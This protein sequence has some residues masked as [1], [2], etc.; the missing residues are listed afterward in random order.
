MKKKILKILIIALVLGGFIGLGYLLMNALG[1][2]NIDGLRNIV[3]NSFAGTIIFAVILI[4]QVIILPAGTLFFS[5]AAVVL[6]ES[7]LKAWLV[8]WFAL[9]IGSWIMF[10]IAR[11]LGM[12][13][14]KWVVGQERAEKYANFLGR[15]KYVLPL[16]LLVPIF[17]D[18]IVCAAAGLSN[19][20]WLYF[21]IVV[22]IT[23]GIDNFCTVFIGASLL[24][25][26]VGIIVLSLFIVVMVI[27][28]YFLTKH[29]DKIENYFLEKFTRKKKNKNSK[30][31]PKQNT[32]D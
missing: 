5:G 8:C 17:P 22:F 2:N 30:E 14:L 4:L 19:I 1:I 21:M 7:P 26:T 24:K 15:G 9:A 32:E 3:D 16:I 13:V 29:Q 27:A 6:F 23:R 25:S 12:K 10:F 20:N 11:F 28:S 18:D 31:P